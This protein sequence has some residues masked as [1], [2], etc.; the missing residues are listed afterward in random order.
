MLLMLMQQHFAQIAASFRINSNY[1]VY[2]NRGHKFNQTFP[3]QLDDT[4][5]GRYLKKF[6][7]DK[8][9]IRV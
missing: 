1:S 8:V 5:E 6:F 9:F 3:L 2:L 7:L 4:N